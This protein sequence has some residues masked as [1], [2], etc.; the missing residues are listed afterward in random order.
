MKQ[1][2]TYLQGLFEEKSKGGLTP[3]EFAILS[4]SADV[5]KLLLEYGAISNTSKQTEDEYKGLDV[6]GKKMDWALDHQAPQ[7]K[8][9]L[10]PFY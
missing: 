3:F 6:G 10:F 7:G 9:S 2:E 1:K 4:G 5:A 8:I